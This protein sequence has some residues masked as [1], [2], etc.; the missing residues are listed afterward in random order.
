[1]PRSSKLNIN[2]PLPAGSGD[3]VYINVF[4]EILKPAALKFDPELVLMSAGFDAHENDTLGQMKLTTEGFARLTEIA[5]SIADKC[6]NGRLISVLEGGYNLQAL[7][8]SVYAHINV[9]IRP[10]D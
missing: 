1:M 4:E 10:K 5:K 8:D 6:C 2:V 9:L 7:A 3:D